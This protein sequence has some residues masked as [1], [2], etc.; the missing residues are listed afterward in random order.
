MTRDLNVDQVLDSW[1]ID[2]PTQLPDRTVAAIV[3]GLDDVQQRRPIGLPR[4]RNMNRSLPSWA[5]PPRSCC[6]PR[7]PSGLL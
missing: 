7:W 1:F 5:Q 4:S 2:G 3:E 6:S